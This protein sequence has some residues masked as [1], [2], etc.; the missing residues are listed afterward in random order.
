MPKQIFSD[1]IMGMD[2]QNGT[3]QDLVG[4]LFINGKPQSYLIS[5]DT[6]TGYTVKRDIRI[7][8]FPPMNG[9]PSRLRA[10]YYTLD[11]HQAN[12]VSS[13]VDCD[14]EQYNE[15]NKQMLLS[16]VFAQDVEL[17]RIDPSRPAG[18]I[19]VLKPSLGVKSKKLVFI[20]SEPYKEMCDFALQD[21]IP[22][23]TAVYIGGNQVDIRMTH[24]YDA[25][26]KDAIMRT[27]INNFLVMTKS[28]NSRINYSSLVLPNQAAY[29]PFMYHGTKVRCPI[30]ENKEY[31]RRYETYFKELDAASDDI[32][33]FPG[34]T[35][36]NLS[37]KVITNKKACEILG[38]TTVYPLTGYILS[39]LII[40]KCAGIKVDIPMLL[41]SEIEYFS[42]YI[43]EIKLRFGSIDQFK[44]SLESE[45]TR[46][47]GVV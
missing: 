43:N 4:Q 3:I 24:A 42:T 13:W 11:K 22:E 1:L 36:S 23:N 31:R 40:Y 45:L 26:L 46:V 29:L 16:G 6:T 17:E 12:K 37:C 34:I 9:V 28:L 47:I 20:E 35:G 5:F 15:F 18:T 21:R 32:Q 38:L 2:C 14:E 8:Y 25:V 19:S 44:A 30:L 39:C 33:I 41:G 10:Q 27:M 7:K